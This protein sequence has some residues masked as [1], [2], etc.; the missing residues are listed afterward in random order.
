MAFRS[1]ADQHVNWEEYGMKI[2]IPKSVFPLST[3]KER[4]ISIEALAGGKF[5]F[6]SGMELVS[7]VYSINVN[8]TLDEPI[9]LKIEH[10]VHLTDKAELKYLKFAVASHETG[11]PYQFKFVEGGKFNVG[12]RYGVIKRKTFSL[13]CIGLEG[14]SGDSSSSSDEEEE[15]RGHM[16]QQT[17]H[18]QPEEEEGGEEGSDEDEKDSGKEKENGEGEGDGSS[19]NDLSQSNEDGSK[20]MCSSVNYFQRKHLLTRNV[21]N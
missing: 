7:A 4:I 17:N 15:D 10:C 11:P 18:Y 12:N 13:I 16:G 21:T 14:E 8:E 2:S 9:T 20:G 5:M 6:P 19:L 3:T 1:N